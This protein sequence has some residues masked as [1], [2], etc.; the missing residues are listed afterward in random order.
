MTA[1]F[2]DFVLLVKSMRTAQ[3][4]YFKTRNKDTLRQSIS[5]EAEVDSYIQEYLSD[6]H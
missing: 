2:E 4:Q 5:L 1:T 6:V 3:K